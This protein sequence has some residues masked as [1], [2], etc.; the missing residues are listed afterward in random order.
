MFAIG[1]FLCKFFHDLYP[2]DRRENF[3][4][5]GC[6]YRKGETALPNSSLTSLGYLNKLILMMLNPRENFSL[7]LTDLI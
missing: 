1:V 6:K 5:L 3:D 2:F 4:E 7:N